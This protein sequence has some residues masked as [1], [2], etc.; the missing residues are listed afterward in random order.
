[1]MHVDAPFLE[2]DI[3]VLA[4]GGSS[5]FLPPIDTFVGEMCVCFKPMIN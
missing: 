3:G 1:M 4:L 2:G 5:L